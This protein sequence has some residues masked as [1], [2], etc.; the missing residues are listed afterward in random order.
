MCKALAVLLLGVFSIPLAAFAED[1][2]STTPQLQCPTLT[3]S[4]ERGS[5][6]ASVQELQK[7]LA[8][9]YGVDQS[10]LVSGFFGATTQS[11]VRRYQADNGLPVLG[12]VGPM[13]REH[14]RRACAKVPVLP[15]TDTTSAPAPSPR[16]NRGI[17]CKISASPISIRPNQPVTFSWS[18]TGADYAVWGSGD[19]DNANE[20]SRV[21][22]NIS[23][24]TVFALTFF[25]Q[26]GSVTCRLKVEVAGTETIEQ[27]PVR[28][29]VTDACSTIGWVEP[30]SPCDGTWTPRYSGGGC[31][32]GWQ[33]LG[34]PKEPLQCPQVM[35]A[36]PNPEVSYGSDGCK[37]LKCPTKVPT[38]TLPSV[39]P[40]I[41]YIPAPCNG[42][43]YA[44]QD[45][46]GCQTGF[47]CEV[48]ST[49][50]P[51]IQKPIAC[52]AIWSQPILPCVGGTKPKYDANGCQ[53]G[54]EC[55]ANDTVGGGPGSCKTPWGD[56]SLT[57]GQTIPYEPYFSN[58]SLS[59]TVMIPLVKCFKSSWLLCDTQGANCRPLPQLL[60][61]LEPVGQK[62]Q[63]TSFD[64]SAAELAA[65][66]VAL[67]NTV[68]SVLSIFGR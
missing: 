61:Q 51:V 35:P 39:C 58:G 5:R 9:R 50:P 45:A 27:K 19:K 54:I 16:E 13:T 65:A 28:P 49:T 22:S 57:E 26:S 32:I 53:V 67:Q 11:Y 36:C 41:A 68:T 43:L 63:E 14:M 55:T 47:R 33:C 29:P 30:T 62:S 40:M 17:T 60:R 7:F 24:T 25:G 38:T 10:V 1:S 3:R 52:P 4:L 37:I 46:N 8:A 31:Q 34:K 12:I 56:R 23:S 20:T 2:V 44:T 6:D 21:F 66:L 59:T 64:R 48:G 42:T 18:S 15:A